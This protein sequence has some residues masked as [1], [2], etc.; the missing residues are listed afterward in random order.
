MARRYSE[1]AA[2]R[3]EPGYVWRS[4]QE[5]RLAMIREHVDVRGR[6]LDNGCG[7]GT[8]LA[9]LSPFSDSRF[10]L[11]VEADRARQA[12]EVASGVVVGVGEM[13][14]FPTATFDFVFSNE[15][16]EHVV[17]DRR[18]AIEM[19]RVARPGGRILI[20]CPNRWYPVE[21]HGI[22][23]RGE[24]K[25][26]NIPLVNYLPRALRNRLAPHVRTYTAPDI[27]RLFRDLPV[28]V[29]HHSQIF[30]GYDNIEHRWPTLGGALK[31]ILYRLEKTPLQVLGISHLLVLEKQMS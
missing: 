11:E 12:A 19:V 17:D 5:R 26:G 9:A 13:L 28:V 3:G 10:G 21:Q 23:W 1:K 29:V 20:F 2:F 30:G 8:Y 18:Y 22:F 7:L 27:R 25:F 15:V 14:P 4:G 6:I 31:Q 24:Y 16:I